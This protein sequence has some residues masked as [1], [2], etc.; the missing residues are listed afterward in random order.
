VV[1]G[2]AMIVPAGLLRRLQGLGPAPGAHAEET[3]V[4]E[5]LAVGAVLAAERRLGNRP[6]DVGAEKRGY[7]VESATGDGRLRFIEVKGRAKG[8]REVTVT[9]NEVLT[10][11]NKPDEYIL[12]LAEVDGGRVMRLV[13]VRRPFGK[14]PD[15]G[16][17]RLDYDLGELLARG[18]EPA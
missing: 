2:G 7:D 18:E 16:V 14:E 11:L 4:S 12:A 5:R 15:F 10:G 17:T 6:R 9:R 8:A 13:Y 1:I 3:T